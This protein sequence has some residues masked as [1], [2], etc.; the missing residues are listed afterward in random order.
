MHIIYTVFPYRNS[1]VS[2]WATVLDSPNA[3]LGDLAGSIARKNFSSATVDV[4]RHML[5][6]PRMMC[7][8]KI[9]L[10]ITIEP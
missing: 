7:A 1:R 3:H 4:A 10:S 5:G 6:E 2:W 9:P 8:A